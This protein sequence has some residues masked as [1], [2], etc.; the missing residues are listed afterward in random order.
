LQTQPIIT[1]PHQCGRSGEAWSDERLHAFKRENPL[2]PNTVPLWRSAK[3]S[4]D[5]RAED[6]TA[7][8]NAIIGWTADI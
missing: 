1:H 3:A 2:N 7:T 4:L 5:M 6:K 8:D